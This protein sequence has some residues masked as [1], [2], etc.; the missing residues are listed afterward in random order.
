MNHLIAVGPAGG[1]LGVRLLKAECD[2]WWFSMC[3]TVQI[4]EQFF[5]EHT[6]R[7]RLKITPAFLASLIQQRAERE[8]AAFV[9]T[10][11]HLQQGGRKIKA[12]V[13]AAQ[14]D[15][16]YS[17]TRLLGQENCRTMAA[18]VCVSCLARPPVPWLGEMK[19]TL[20]LTLCA[21]RG[22]KW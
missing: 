13:S 5:S 17:W 4:V 9:S 6:W 20:T 15:C 19:L 12:A 1:S 21:R 16:L 22:L 7:K 8:K 2:N 11:T 18:G 14:T 10:K 3:T